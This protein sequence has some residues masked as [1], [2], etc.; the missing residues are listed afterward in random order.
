MQE[1]IKIKGKSKLV[2]YVKNCGYKFLGWETDYSDLQSKIVLSNK[3]TNNVWETPL[4]NFINKPKD[5]S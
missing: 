5:H 3:R 1:L 4:V 2:I